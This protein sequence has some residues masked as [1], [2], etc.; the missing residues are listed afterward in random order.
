[1][2]DT[3]ASARPQD[4]LD[5][6]VP[7]AGLAPGAAPDALHRLAWLLFLVVKHRLLPPH[8]DLVSLFH[9]LLAVVATLR[10]HAP[11]APAIG[12]GGAADDGVGPA[13]STLAA[14]AAAHKASAE[15]VREKAARRHQGQ[16]VTGFCMAMRSMVAVRAERHSSG[17]LTDERPLTI[18]LPGSG[19]WNRLRACCLQYCSFAEESVPN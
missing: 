3:A 13:I 15:E 1:M 9:L 14:L 19:G 10:D 12:A 2:S 6:Y 11:W 16:H 18:P 7:S 4:L 8:P 17:R 5:S